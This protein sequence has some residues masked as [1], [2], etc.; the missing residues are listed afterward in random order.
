MKLLRQAAGEKGVELRFLRQGKHEVWRLGTERLVIPRH[1][2]I[3]EHTALA[4]LRQ[5]RKS[6]GRSVR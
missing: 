4:I 5:A 6:T 3:D 2:E 1:N